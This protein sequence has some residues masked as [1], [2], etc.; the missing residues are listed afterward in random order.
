VT[1]ARGRILA[2]A[3][4]RCIPQSQL[5]TI[6]NAGHG[7]PTENPAAFNEALLAFLERLTRQAPHAAARSTGTPTP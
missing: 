4:H 5:V 6:P 7:A 1:K 2:D 3:A